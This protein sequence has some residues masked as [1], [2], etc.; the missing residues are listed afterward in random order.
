MENPMLEGTPFPNLSLS[1]FKSVD[2]LTVVIDLDGVI[3]PA[4]L[5]DDDLLG[6]EPVVGARETISALM[7][8]G[9]K[10]IIWTARG[11]AM[12]TMTEY[13]LSSRNIPFDEL[14]LDKPRATIYIDDKA[15]RFRSWSEIIEK[16]LV[17]Q[18]AAEPIV[19]KDVI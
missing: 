15:W 10:V 16:L 4:S 1:E 5:S 19:K 18:P 2:P 3:V 11:E 7:K 8:M 13:W 9:V 14:R 6:R 12:R 17:P